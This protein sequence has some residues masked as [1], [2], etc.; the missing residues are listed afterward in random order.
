MSGLVKG[1]NAQVLDTSKLDKAVAEY[2]WKKSRGLLD[3]DEDVTARGLGCD[4]A[5]LLKHATAPRMPPMTPAQFGAVSATKC[6]TLRARDEPLVRSM[7]RRALQRMCDTDV[8]DYR[9][10]GWK[11]ADALQVAK[12]VGNGWAAKCR[13][14]FLAYN[15]IGDAGVRDA[16]H[17][18]HRQTGRANARR[19]SHTHMVCACACARVV[20]R[21]A[22][23]PTRCVRGARA[24][25]RR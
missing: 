12:M 25:S 1:H 24:P 15:E 22:R 19:A 18:T 2:R 13:R 14:L 11:D 21:C 5:M 16:P 7:Y 20:G 17:R 23:S 10:L 3:D 8:L 9:E 4:L 6:F